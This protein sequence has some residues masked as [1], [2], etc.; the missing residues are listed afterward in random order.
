MQ[1]TAQI[2]VDLS[3]IIDRDWGQFEELLV[4]YAW[5]LVPVFDLNYR[6]LDTD[7]SSQLLIEVS[8]DVDPELDDHNTDVQEEPQ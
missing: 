5:G 4:E 3:E 2:W 1:K 7:K 6:L 8:G